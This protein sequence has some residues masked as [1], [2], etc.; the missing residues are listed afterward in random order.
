[1]SCMRCRV[2][3]RVQGVFF[4]QSTRERARALGLVGHALNRSDGSVEVL[5]CGPDA[6]LAELREWLGEG[7]RMAVVSDLDCQPAEAPEPVPADFTT[8]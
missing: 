1:M 2:T 7:P 6:A 8:G 4:R 5:A 3:G